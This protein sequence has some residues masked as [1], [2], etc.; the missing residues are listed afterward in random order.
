MND[1]SSNWSSFLAGMCIGAG[2]AFL[3]APQSGAQLRRSIRDYTDDARDQLNEATDRG[4]AAWDSAVDQGREY[5]S[6]FV[7][8]GTEAVRET[9]KTAQREGEGIRHRARQAVREQA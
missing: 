2:I 1:S 8:R 5:V 6:E 9:V 4:M 7:E 3:L